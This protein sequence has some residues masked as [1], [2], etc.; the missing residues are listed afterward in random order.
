MDLFL[1]QLHSLETSVKLFDNFLIGVMFF[2][3]FLE[4]FDWHNVICLFCGD[5]AVGLVN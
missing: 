4:L 3:L 5:I 1:E 2:Y